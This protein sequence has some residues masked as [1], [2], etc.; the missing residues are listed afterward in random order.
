[1]DTKTFEDRDL[2]F[3]SPELPVKLLFLL[4]VVVVR[5][6]NQGKQILQLTLRLFR[7]TCPYL[8]QNRRQNNWTSFQN[9][10]MK[11]KVIGKFVGRK[12]ESM[13]ATPEGD[14]GQ[15]GVVGSGQEMTSFVNFEE[16]SRHRQGQGDDDDDI[17][18][19]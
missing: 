7:A 10:G 6:R 17:D 16:R 18:V 8:L 4:L 14:I 2:P 15:V 1:M 3:V 13:F 11:R 9:K 5:W 19:D 12:K